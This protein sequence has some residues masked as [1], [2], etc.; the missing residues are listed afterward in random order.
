MKSLTEAVEMLSQEGYLCKYVSWGLGPSISITKHKNEQ[1]NGFQI[2]QHTIF[3]APENNGWCVI[4][5]GGVSVF[6]KIKSLSEAVNIAVN[7]L[8][9]E[10]NT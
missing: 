8:N 6:N 4:D 1:V 3:I 10:E 9:N 5:K 2:I 7:C